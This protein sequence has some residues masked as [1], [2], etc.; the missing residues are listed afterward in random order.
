[1]KAYSS[2]LT[3]ALEAGGVTTAGAVKIATTAGF[4]VW[5]GEGTITLDGEDYVGIGDRGLVQD[6]GSQLGGA[7]QGL[8]LTLSGVDSDVIP[9]IHAAN[10][11]NAPARVWQLLF[12]LS[13]A[14]FLGAFPRGGRIDS[15]SIEDVPG[16]KATIRARS[17]SAAK[18]MGRMTGRQRSDAD[19]R[20]LNPTDGGMQW[21][22]Q[23][24]L[25]SLAWGGKP[26]ARVASGILPGSVT[27]GGGGVPS[28]VYDYTN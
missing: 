6:L 5:G 10:I 4:R 8:E 18:N 11:R 7:E 21:A 3:A 14:N 20:T 15:L 24:P 23:A 25:R 1:M 9:I 12:D 2:Q 27:A 17:E 22:T 19:Q 28:A 26:P 16:G 13:G